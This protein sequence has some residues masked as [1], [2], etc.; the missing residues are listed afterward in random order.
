MNHVALVRKA[1]G[2]EMP[3]ELLDDPLM[4]QGASDGFLGP[5]DPIAVADEGFGIDLEAEVAVITDDVPMGSLPRRRS[6]TS[7]WSCC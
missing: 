5:T 6:A 3:A 7:S 2:A 1:R 4:Y